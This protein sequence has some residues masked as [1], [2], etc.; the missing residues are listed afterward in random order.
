MKALKGKQNGNCAGEAR[1]MRHEANKRASGNHR[2]LR[3]YEDNPNPGIL[4]RN[5][6]ENAL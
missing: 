1:S 6:N 3:V 5:I 4:Q 2:G